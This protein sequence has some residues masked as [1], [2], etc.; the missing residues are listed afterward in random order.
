VRSPQL[1]ATPDDAAWNAAPV[2]TA[3][4]LLQDMV[5]PRLLAASTPSVRVQAITDGE[6]VAFRLAW[7][8]STRD[9][10][11]ATSQF[12]DAC[13]VQLPQLAGPD[14]PAPQMGEAGRT[15]EMTF[16]S[17][18]WQAEVEGRGTSIQ[19]L[20]PNAAVDHYP[21]EA[22]TLKPGA[23]E[24][25]AM[26]RRYAP[27][28]ASQRPQH[29]QDRPVQDLIAEGPGTITPAPQTRSNGA[30]RWAKNSWEVVLVR[31][32]PEALLGQTNSQVAFA[33]W[34][35]SRDEVG[36]R[37]MRSVWIPL[38]LEKES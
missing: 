29:P 9:D 7:T 6:R 17:A 15:V 34:N 33:I 32:L 11:P 12:V 10:A 3:P 14:L 24:Q 21:F 26:E 16:W 30:G 31:T 36:A 18:A 5:E 8:D 27:A 38:S 19:E 20:Y 2:H 22:P 28:K 35:G 1:P 37:K 25:Q 13:A 4:L 23:P